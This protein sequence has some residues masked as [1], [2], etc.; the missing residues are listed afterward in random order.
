[1]LAPLGCQPQGMPHVVQRRANHVN[2]AVQVGQKG[3]LVSVEGMEGHGEVVD[4]A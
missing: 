1:M 2:R 4:S 3:G